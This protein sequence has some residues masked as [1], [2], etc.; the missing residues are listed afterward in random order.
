MD[1]LSSA[2]KINTR[3]HVIYEDTQNYFD[4]CLTM[5]TFFPGTRYTA[6]DNLIHI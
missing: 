3:L 6:S 4:G 2:K 5:G 1:S